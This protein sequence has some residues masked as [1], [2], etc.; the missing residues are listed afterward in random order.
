M[1]GLD[2]IADAPTEQG[3]YFLVVKSEDGGIGA[4]PM[5]LDGSET[6][7]EA[8]RHF[9]DAVI[10]SRQ[11]LAARA[12]YHPNPNHIDGKPRTE[13]ELAGDAFLKKVK[14]D[15][16]GAGDSAEYHRL[17]AARQAAA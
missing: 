10:V 1:T 11:S 13:F 16:A 9:L 15:P 14:Q 4:L 2:I 12:G 7:D 8:A 5:L 3:R 17:I 6:Y